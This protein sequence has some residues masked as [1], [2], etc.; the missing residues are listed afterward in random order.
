MVEARRRLE[1]L[2]EDAEDL[3]SAT[4]AAVLRR[5]LGHLRR[6]RLLGR[7]F[8]GWREEAW[9]GGDE[10]SCEARSF[11]RQHQVAGPTEATGGRGGS[12]VR[13]GSS[14]PVHSRSY[15][16]T[17][18]A[19]PAHR[20]QTAPAFTGEATTRVVSDHVSTRGTNTAL[21]PETRAAAPAPPFAFG[22]LSVSRRI[23]LLE[24]SCR[25]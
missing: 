7:A 3:A 15:Y 16:R 9:I 23:E 6:L 10:R 14:S 25:K 4:K 5:V 17:G 12:F 24:A 22:P 19:R 13:A 8:R 21:L 20:D 18:G 1:G 11:R 2:D